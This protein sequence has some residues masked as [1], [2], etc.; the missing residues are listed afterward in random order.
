MII[1]TMINLRLQ[2][3]KTSSKCHW[4]LRKCHKYQNNLDVRFTELFGYN[5]D[6]KEKMF[7][8]YQ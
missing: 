6:L 2:F 8:K 3:E 1:K 4:P 7:Y 5:K